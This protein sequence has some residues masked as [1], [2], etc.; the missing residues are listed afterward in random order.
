[1]ILQKIKTM[2]VAL[3]LGG[4]AT[5]A[6]LALVPQ[7]VGAALAF[8]GGL[9]GGAAAVSERTARKQQESA[10]AQRV[11]TCFA[12]LYEKNQGLI[13]P[14]QL[15]FLANVPIDKAYGFLAAL[16]ENS[17]GQKVP[18]E[19]GTG[20]LF[21]FPHTEGAL[22]KLTA[23]AQAWAQ[24]QTQDLTNALEQS[25]RTIQY[26]QAQQAVSNMGGQQLQAQ[27]QPALQQDPWTPA[28]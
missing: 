22:A 9:M 26:L 17:N 3:V 12:T 8:T 21:S 1:M 27:P 19:Q 5:I 25:R 15:A 6:T 14:V 4:A 18:V 24:A 13:D 20:V 10:D 2:P 11:S 23:N 7:Q 16:A 28:R